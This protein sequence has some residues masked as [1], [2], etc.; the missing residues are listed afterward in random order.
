MAAEL[1]S[2]LEESAELVKSS[3]GVFEVE[4]RGDLI[5]SKVALR[6]FPVDGEVVEIVRGVEAGMTLADAQ[7]I[8]SAGAPT[9]ISFLE[10]LGNFLKAPSRR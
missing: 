6:R 7:K 9:P 1:E 4:D 10:W 2:K 5:F 3:G 8:A